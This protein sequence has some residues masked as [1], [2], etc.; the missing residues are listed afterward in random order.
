MFRKYVRKKQYAKIK[1]YIEA[2]IALIQ[3]LADHIPDD[4]TDETANISK[5]CYIAQEVILKEVLRS[6]ENEEC[7]S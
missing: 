3:G 7:R 5:S 6:I 1:S 4:E 2:K